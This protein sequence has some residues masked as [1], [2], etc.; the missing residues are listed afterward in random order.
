MKKLFNVTVGGL[1]LCSVVL[2]IAMALTIGMVACD[3]WDYKY[4]QYKVMERSV[5]REY[6]DGGFTEGHA[7]FMD[8]H[9]INYDVGVF[10]PKDDEETETAWATLKRRY[11][12]LWK[13]RHCLPMAEL[14]ELTDVYRRYGN[15][16][17]YLQYGEFC[18]A[19]VSGITVVLSV[20]MMEGKSSNKSWRQKMLQAFGVAMFVVLIDTARYCAEYKVYSRMP[21]STVVLLLPVAFLV[22]PLIILKKT[23]LPKEARLTMGAKA[24]E[25]TRKL[26]ARLMRNGVGSAGAGVP[27]EEIV[28]PHGVLDDSNLYDS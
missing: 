1:Y 2:G 17:Y 21:V 3:T 12:R 18:L 13:V 20:L 19:I 4:N 28:V 5:R 22:I 24:V 23:W 16:G 27:M 8:T 7:V 10:Y 9:S 26:K 14:W 6:P 11:D 25:G 15:D